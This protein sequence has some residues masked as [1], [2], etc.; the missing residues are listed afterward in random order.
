MTIETPPPEVDRRY[1]GRGLLL[2][3]AVGDA[4]GWPQE[5]RSAIVGGARSRNVKPRA[6]FR[7]WRRNSGTQFGRYVET[8][9][10]GE[11]SDDTQLLLAVARACRRGDQWFEYLTNVELPAW[12]SYQR[13]GGRAVLTAARSWLNGHPPWVGG[14]KQTDSGRYFAAGSNG[15]AMRVA[16]HALAACDSRPE[17]LLERV[18]RDGI[19]THGHPRALLGGALHAL[20]LRS[21]LRQSSTLG[22]GELLEQIRA[23]PS[24]R[25]LE[26]GDVVPHDW[27]HAYEQRTARN[28][29]D[30]W[31][32]TVTEVQAMLDVT[33]AAL[34]RGAL[35]DDQAT[36]AELGCFDP[37]VNGSG[38]VSAVASLYIAA[39]SAARP[40]SGL[41]GAAFLKSADTDTLAS[42]VA[43]IL[44]ALHGPDWLG[45]LAAEV[46][47]STYIESF[48]VQSEPR[49][50]SRQTDLFSIDQNESGS[51]YLAPVSNRDVNRIVR[52]LEEGDAREGT[53]LDG[54][55]FMIIERT[56]L[57][58]KTKASV[59]RYRLRLGDGQTIVI[60]QL[61]RISRH[62]APRSEKESRESA[63]AETRTE[64]SVVRR[65]TLLV[66][67]LGTM[68]NFYRNVIG[69]PVRGQG[70]GIIDIGPT[71]RLQMD[72]S[73]HHPGGVLI[74][75]EANDL[76]RIRSA[77]GVPGDPAGSLIECHDPE[78]NRVVVHRA[79]P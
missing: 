47:D 10:A 64:P 26:L 36:L 46:Q 22:Y 35:A 74:E 52:I 70:D 69:L 3:A 38:I 79:R 51:S 32:A 21:L 58:T 45:T 37:K 78:G 6:A 43:S 20:T 68:A 4:L 48:A 55:P 17:E 60:D 12:L 76:E 31:T 54:R 75:V 9:G 53:F 65:V 67:D 42:M 50:T 1:R 24:W 59:T 15:A 16:P 57:D 28:A 7:E 13:G 2:G 77:L 25:R 71:L 49:L 11:Y 29:Q 23:E 63:S 33:G 34:Q 56:A 19:A 66:R 72:R 40:M 41:L 61:R 14:S 62:S 30:D 39:R 44:G 8:V 27:L 73:K 5:Q 18:V